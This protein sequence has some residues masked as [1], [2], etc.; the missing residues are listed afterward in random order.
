MT[1][2]VAKDFVGRDG[3]QHNNDRSEPLE[4]FCRVLPEFVKCL[5]LLLEYVKDRLRVVTAIDLRSERVIAEIFPGSLCV[6]RQGGIKNCLKVKG[7][8]GCIRS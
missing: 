7:R 5:S 8:G 6:L 2:L 1:S 3:M 4:Q